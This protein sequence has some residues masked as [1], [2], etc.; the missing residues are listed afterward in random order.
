MRIFLAILFLLI[1]SMGF[2][3]AKTN[4]NAKTDGRALASE[5]GFSV[6]CYL[7]ITVKPNAN[8]NRAKKLIFGKLSIPA[9]AIAVY[10]VEVGK[11]EKYAYHVFKMENMYPAPSIDQ[12]ISGFKARMQNAKAELEKNGML[13]NASTGFIGCSSAKTTPVEFE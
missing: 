7:Q 10:F 1:P 9:T 12:V 13:A 8:Q 3:D 6:S 5:E 2:S 11:T 4:K